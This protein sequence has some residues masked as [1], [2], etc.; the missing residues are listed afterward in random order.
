MSDE[1]MPIRFWSGSSE[2]AWLSAF[3]RV[4]M[5]DQDGLGWDSLEVWY[6]AGKARDEADGERIGSAPTRGRQSG[7]DA[8]SR[9]ARTGT[10]TATC[11]WP[12]GW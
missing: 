4:S 11:A 7:W 1:T 9:S 10:S 8:P 6:Q 3:K 5:T 12:R 2:G